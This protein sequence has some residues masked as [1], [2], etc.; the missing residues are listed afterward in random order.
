MAGQGL[1]LGVPAFAKGNSKPGLCPGLSTQEPGKRWR[2]RAAPLPPPSA[3]TAG[4]DPGPSGKLLP[5]LMAA[6]GHIPTP[7]PDT[8]TQPPLK[9][10]VK[11]KSY[12]L[13]LVGLF[14]SLPF[15]DIYVPCPTLR[16]CYF[17]N[18]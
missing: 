12:R 17:Y 7:P 6:K 1:R 14:V 8:A 2:F 5:W 3:H 16:V 10:K 11:L 18:I 4:Q 13:Q 15:L 9:L